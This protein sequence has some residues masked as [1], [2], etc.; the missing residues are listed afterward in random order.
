LRRQYPREIKAWEELD[1]KDE[2]ADSDAK[3]DELFE[4]ELTYILHKQ[5]TLIVEIANLSRFLQ[6]PEFHLPALY[7]CCPFWTRI[8]ENSVTILLD[9]EQV[10]KLDPA[11][12]IVCRKARESLL[13]VQTDNVEDLFEV[14]PADVH[15]FYCS[16]PHFWILAIENI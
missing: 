12:V 14:T 15:E 7:R 10:V 8:P 6:L 9:S 1:D 2:L 5:D 11:D 3:T 13:E 4:K 16:T